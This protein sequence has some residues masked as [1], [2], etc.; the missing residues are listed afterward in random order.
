MAASGRGDVWL[1]VVVG[2]VD[3]IEESEGKSAFG[4]RRAGWTVGSGA[5]AG[6]VAANVSRVGDAAVR[7]VPNVRPE[8]AL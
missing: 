7:L 5:F 1:E 4:G 2:S 8:G 6:N 3:C